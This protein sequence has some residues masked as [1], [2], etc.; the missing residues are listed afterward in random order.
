VQ[1]TALTT[2]AA[3]EVVLFGENDITFLRIVIILRIEFWFLKKVAQVFTHDERKGN[4]QIFEFVG[5]V[6]SRIRIIV[7][8]LVN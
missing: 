2:V 4:D 7:F 8:E 3:L 6:G 5:D 1:A